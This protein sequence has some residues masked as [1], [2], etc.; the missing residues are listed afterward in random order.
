[1]NRIFVISTPRS[2]SVCIT[3]ILEQTQRFNIFHEPYVS[4]YDKVHYAELTKNWWKNTAFN[5]SKDIIKAMEEQTDKHILVK[6][7]AFAITDY[8]DH[9]PKNSDFILLC[10]NPLNVL[11]SLYNKSKQVGDNNN[12]EID[13]WRSLSGFHQLLA[14]KKKLSNN[15]NTLILSTDNILECTKRIFKF[16]NIEFKSAYTQWSPC[17]TEEE[18]ANKSTQWRENKNDILFAHWHKEALQSNGVQ[19]NKGHS[20]QEIE[21]IKDRNMIKQLSDELLPIYHELLS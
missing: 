15:Y 14:L 21:N 6:D 20:I 9:I 18:I 8:I 12:L 16:L 4:V 11:V 7:M 3:R 2:N 5:E 1:M 13:D 10:R 17:I 19:N